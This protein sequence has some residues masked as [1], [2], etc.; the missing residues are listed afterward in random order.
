[1]QVKAS[2]TIAIKDL[3]EFFR[4]GYHLDQDDIDEFEKDINA[5]KSLK[6][7]DWGNKWD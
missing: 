2:N 5:V 6:L 4:N 3:N 7:Q 1:M